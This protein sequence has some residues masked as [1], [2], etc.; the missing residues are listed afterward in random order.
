[1]TTKERETKSSI[2]GE[3][4]EEFP[5]LPVVQKREI[6]LQASDHQRSELVRRLI[7]TDEF[8]EATA[9]STRLTAMLYDMVHHD[10][11]REAG[12][13]GYWDHFMG[14]LTDQQ[15][16]AI[17]VRV[18]EGYGV[19][20]TSSAISGEGEEAAIDRIMRQQAKV[21]PTLQEAPIAQ[22]S[23]ISNIA[24]DLTNEAFD[25]E[26]AREVG[27]RLS[28]EREYSIPL[29]DLMARIGGFGLQQMIELYPEASDIWA[30]FF[31]PVPELEDLEED[32]VYDED[33]E[34]EDADG[35]YDLYRE[36]EE[37]E[38]EE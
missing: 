9:E 20:P 2:P 23:R 21:D 12:S 28:D 37:D 15:L 25:E 34:K 6:F 13:K 7:V 1:M 16:A 26:A 27:E 3:S 19:S 24:P 32:E 29:H 30:K 10:L 38:D 33:E 36:D 35:G 31:L 5:N 11:H 8:G 17:M 14:F 18:L 22:T 4:I